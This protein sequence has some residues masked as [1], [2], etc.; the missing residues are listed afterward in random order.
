VDREYKRYATH[1]GKK[2][3]C[4]KVAL[5]GVNT[6]KNSALRETQTTE[7]GI[8]ISKG[9]QK[10]T[11][12]KIKPFKN[13]KLKERSLNSH[14]RQEKE[15]QDRLVRRKL[16]NFKLLKKAYP[17]MFNLLEVETTQAQPQRPE[18]EELQRLYWELSAH[19]NKTNPQVQQTRA[20]IAHWKRLKSKTGKKIMPS[21]WIGTGCVDLF[22]PNI[23]APK[24]DKSKPAGSGLAI[25]IDGDVHNLETKMLKDESK[26]RQ[27]QILKVMKM[28]QSNWDINSESFKSFC[29][30]INNLSSLSYSERRRM[31]VKIFAFTLACHF[32]EDK[33]RRVFTINNDSLK[34][35]AEEKK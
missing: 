10:M 35:S 28:S 24:L 22:I 17:R 13:K 9:D 8:A 30:R 1:R 18:F 12:R 19:L 20:E 26:S 7:N 14:I 4:F 3:G 33:F 11:I 2:G 27:L 25:E 31:R 21:F 23:R 6:S 5:S 34:N 32:S 29:L 15:T 16:G